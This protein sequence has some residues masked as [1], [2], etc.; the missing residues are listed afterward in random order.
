M[1]AFGTNR[2]TLHYPYSARNAKSN[3]LEL[4]HG[5]EK[6]TRD[7]A[8]PANKK[9]PYGFNGMEEM[10]YGGNKTSRL[11]TPSEASHTSITLFD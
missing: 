4:T 11:S 7:T 1:A 5:L 2:T 3:I 9:Y 8:S 6:S 10:H